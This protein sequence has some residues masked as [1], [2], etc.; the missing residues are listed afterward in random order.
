MLNTTALVTTLSNKLLARNL[1]VATVESCTGGGLAYQLTSL[2]GSSTWF[3][4]GFVTYSNAAKISLVAVDPKILEQHGA[5]SQETALA[6]ASGGLKLSHADL[7]VSITGIAGPD[8]GTPTKPVGTVWFAI[9]SKFAAPQ[10]QCVHFKGARD[11]V[12]EQSINAALS[13]IIA[14]LNSHL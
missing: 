8:G 7:C 1:V 3:E 14:Y 12:R 11:A 9:A 5:V 13:L 10:A 2:A 6:M 4:R